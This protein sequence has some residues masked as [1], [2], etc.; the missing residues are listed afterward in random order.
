MSTIHPDGS[1]ERAHVYELIAPRATHVLDP[2]RPPTLG[3]TLA[4]FPPGN[5]RVARGQQARRFVVRRTCKCVSVGFRVSERC[6]RPE[7]VSER[8]RCEGE[9]VARRRDHATRV[10][11]V[12]RQRDGFQGRMEPD[13]GLS[14]PPSFDHA[15][16]AQLVGSVDGISEEESASITNGTTRYS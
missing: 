4:G 7:D 2:A 14:S 6:R 8:R 1:R 10:H 12:A 13:A 3:Y 15:A 11:F 5:L 9:N 16:L